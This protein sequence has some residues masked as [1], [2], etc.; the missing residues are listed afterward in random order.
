HPGLILVHTAYGEQDWLPASAPAGG[1]VNLTIYVGQARSVVVVVQSGQA[2]AS[3]PVS[4]Y[5][6]VSP[7]VTVPPTTTQPNWTILGQKVLYNTTITLYNPSPDPLTD[8]TLNLTLN[9]T[10][11]V[12][13]KYAISQQVPV[14]G[15]TVPI[16][17]I[18]F[19]YKGPNGLVPL[20]AWIEAY[21]S[22]VADIWVR[23]PPSLVIPGESYVSIYVLFLA[24]PILNTGYL[25]VNS[26]Y[27]GYPPYDNIGYVM[28]KGLLYQIYMDNSSPPSVFV[29]SGYMQA[30]L[31]ELYYSGY[32]YIYPT[33]LFPWI[34]WLPMANVVQNLTITALTVYGT[35]PPVIVPIIPAQAGGTFYPI[36]KTPL[37]SGFTPEG[38]VLV[39]I[40]HGNNLETITTCGYDILFNWTVSP[41]GTTDWPGGVEPS[42]GNYFLKAVGWISVETSV[43]PSSSY[44][45]LSADDYGAVEAEPAAYTWTVSNFSSWIPG[46]PPS[47]VHAMAANI[48]GWVSNVVQ[49]GSSFSI[50]DYLP[51]LGVYLTNET[52]LANFVNPVGDYRVVAIYAAINPNNWSGFPMSDFDAYW[53]VFL[54]QGSLNACPS[55]SARLFANMFW[56]SPI[57]PSTGEMPYLY[58]NVPYLFVLRGQEILPTPPGAPY[59]SQPG[60]GW[61][62]A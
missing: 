37:N 62:V 10:N 52:S 42:M 40:M 24:N 21:N 4:T 11:P 12:V 17:N 51:Y 22:T 44:I 43:Y 27:T 26:F 9:L 47:D 45:V 50:A 1:S 61:I 28:A 16:A 8:F 18:L 46:L 29:N 7:Y 55:S 30:I 31:Q 38:T 19:A 53:V 60:Y 56:Y 15:A 48:S 32:Q 3:V 41:N 49:V 2:I 6:V 58:S 59:S 54:H 35:S 13:Q 36:F 39:S 25:G 34:Y 23:I 57:F 5:M 20:Y 14:T 33:G